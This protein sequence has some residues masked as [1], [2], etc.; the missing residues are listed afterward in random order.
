MYHIHEI[1]FNG[2]EFNNTARAR[3]GAESEPRFFLDERRIFHDKKAD[4][5]SVTVTVVPEIGCFELKK[6]KCT[7]VI[8]MAKVC[9]E[10]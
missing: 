3:E 5:D 1:E 9:F 2:H 10:G 4:G 8:D 7:E 6:M